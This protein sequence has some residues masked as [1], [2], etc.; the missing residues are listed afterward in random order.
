MPQRFICQVISQVIGDHPPSCTIPFK[1]ST[2]KS[3]N[4]GGKNGSMQA[5][6]F[7]IDQ[8]WTKKKKKTQNTNSN[9]PLD[10]CDFMSKYNGGHAMF[11]EHCLCHHLPLS[12]Q[13]P[14]TLSHTYA[15]TFSYLSTHWTSQTLPEGNISRSHSFIH[16]IYSQVRVSGGV[17]IMS[18][19]VW[20][21]LVQR[22]S[23]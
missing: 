11:D 2:L 21:L 14:A 15:P 4:G 17:S 12:Q 7:L 1:T 6:Y 9:S 10:W 19:C 3:C 13:I 5:H 23:I 8:K 18:V 22:S 16:C 20:L